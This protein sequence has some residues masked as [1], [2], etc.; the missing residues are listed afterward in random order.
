[1]GLSKDLPSI[2]FRRGVRLPVASAGRLRPVSA[3]LRDGNA[4][5]IRVPSPWFFT[6][7]TVFSSTPSR[8]FA[9]RFRSW[10]SPRFVPLRDGIPR[11]ALTALRSFPS[12]D[13]CAVPE[14]NLRFHAGSRQWLDRLRSLRSP[15][16]LPPRPSSGLEALLHRRVRCSCGR[17][18]PYAPGAPLG[19]SDPPGRRPVPPSVA[20]SGDGA[21]GR[22]RSRLS[23]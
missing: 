10:G 22:P 15:R 1:M 2:V 14:T 9:G 13:S 8:P 19:L 5:P 18:Q 7:S 3:D 20:A 16:T 23:A 11:G 6:T 12:A 4:I 17:F 21:R